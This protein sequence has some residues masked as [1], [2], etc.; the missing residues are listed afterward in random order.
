MR[1]ETSQDV[2][3]RKIKT[4]ENELDYFFR[5]ASK[6]SDSNQ[7]EDEINSDE[8][9][10]PDDLTAQTQLREQ[11]LESLRVIAEW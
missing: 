7:Q 8:A 11:Q 9:N 1:H 3:A 4:I 2:I 5:C 10:A 6:P